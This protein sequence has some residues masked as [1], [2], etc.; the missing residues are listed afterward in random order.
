MPGGVDSVEVDRV[1]VAG[2][3]REANPQPLAL[4]GAERRPRHSPVVRPRG[5]LHAGRHLDLLLLGHELPLAHAADHA[6]LV[7]VAQDLLRIEAVHARVDGADRAGVG[8]VRGGAGSH[9]MHV[10]LSRGGFE[11]VVE[12]PVRDQLVQHGQGRRGGR[13]ATQQTPP[14]KFA[15][16]ELH[17]L[18]RTNFMISRA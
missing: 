13:R 18:P 4:A 15:L 11:R 8:R 12:A 14:G 7:E 9:A 5:V 3:V 10:R 17:G 16:T 1:R 2:P 6:A